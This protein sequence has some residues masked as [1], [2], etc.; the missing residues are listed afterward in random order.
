MGASIVY[1]LMSSD[2]NGFRLKLQQLLEA[3]GTQATMVGT[4]YSGNMTDNHH[5][6]Y[7]GLEISAYNNKSYHSGAYEMGANVVLVHIGTND[8]WWIKGENGTGGARQMGYLMDSIQAKLP[9]ALVLLSTLIRSTQAPQDECLR[10]MNAHFPAVVDAAVAKGQMAR[11]V[12]MYDVVQPDQMGPDGT[13]PT[14][15]GYH[16]MGQQWFDAVGNATKDLCVDAP[17]KAVSSTS[18]LVATSTATA[19][20][21]SATGSSVQEVA[22]TQSPTAASSAMT[23]VSRGLLGLLVPAIVMVMPL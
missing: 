15:L 5:E 23:V 6:A 19:T 16:L 9:D 11:L 22:S 17:L 14:D 3:N 21:S 18:S 13:H 1:G 20:S 10:G 12:D 8:C 7:Q 4:Q 2:G